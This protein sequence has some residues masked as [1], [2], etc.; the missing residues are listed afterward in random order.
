[1]EHKDC[2]QNYKTGSSKA[3]EASATLELILDLYD[4]GVD[5]EFIVS[6]DDSII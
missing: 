5:V 4:L 2:P 6:D 3:M 1:M